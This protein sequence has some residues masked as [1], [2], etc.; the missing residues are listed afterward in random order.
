MSRARRPV[1]LNQGGIICT[2]GADLA[3]VE[4]NLFAV[5]EHS[6]LTTTDH[7]SPG[8]PQSL[9]QVPLEL[10][11]VTIPCEDTRNNR[12]LAA[13]VSPLL[14]A[15]DKLKSRLGRQRI[16]IVIGTSTSGIAE[17]ESALTRVDN[18]IQLAD[19]YRYTSQELSAP[20]RFLSNWLDVAGPCWTVSSACTSGGKALT[21]AARLLDL[22]VCDVVIAGGVDT[23]CRMTVGGFSSLFVTADTPCNP[24]SRNRSG[25]N[26]GEGAGVFIL[27]REPGPVRL[28]GFGES[29][30]AYHISS[31]HPQ[32]IG[33]H[34]AI[35]RALDMAGLKSEDIDY[36]N[37]HGTATVQNDLMEGL[38][39]NRVFGNEVACSSTKPLTGHTLAAA[40][41]IEAMLCWLLLQ[42]DD[43]LLP[44]HLWDGQ[45]D[46]EIPLLNGLGRAD[47]GR[48]V[49]AAMSSSFAF[50][51]NNLSLILVREES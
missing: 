24:F 16:G 2:L 21:S 7:Y 28:A 6:F 19:G 12:M 35:V 43:G 3:N 37:L 49:K 29:S 14:P 5:Q 39:V 25:T 9:G 32:G 33:A 1:Y 47:L 11:A 34:D 23:L 31:P 51:G 8:Q 36:L 27:S 13:A 26:I 46:P 45:R 38:A 18:Q 41:A 50:G 30:D 20:T 10:P 42:R 44:P 22:G 4:R 40:G 17:G 48:P 15:I